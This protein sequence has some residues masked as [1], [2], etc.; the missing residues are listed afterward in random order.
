MFLS[1]RGVWATTYATNYYDNGYDIPDSNQLAVVEELISEFLEDTND[2]DCSD[3]NN[4]LIAIGDAITALSASGG[5]GCGSGDAGSDEPPG[6]TQTVDPPGTPGG[7]VPPGFL[8]LAEYETYKCD[9]ASWIVDQLRADVV[10][11]QLGTVSTMTLTIFISLLV[12]PVP[13]ARV[14]ALLFAV[15][16][17]SGLGASVFTVFLAAIDNH[18]DDLVC[19]LYEATDVATAASDYNAAFDTAVDAETSDLA[20]R[21][22]IKSVFDLMTSNSVINKLFDK[23]VYTSFGSGDCTGCGIAQWWTAMYGTPLGWGADWVEVQATLAGGIWFL[24]ISDI[25][26]CPTVWE[27]NAT[28]IGG[29]YTNASTIWDTVAEPCP[30][31]AD[32]LTGGDPGLWN[33][34]WSN[35][36]YGPHVDVSAVQWRSATSFSLRIVKS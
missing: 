20:F 23:D 33:R 34:K 30:A 4:S 22:A 28:V 12:T 9:V 35:H 14:A 25:Q 36:F 1:S 11:W 10:F 31:D 7:T 21:F 2:M 6:S 16:A 32:A 3:F 29:S 17:L 19:A 24:G 18:R 26:Q 5:C 27:I 13:G 8:D 15:V